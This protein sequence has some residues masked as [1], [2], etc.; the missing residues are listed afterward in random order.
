MAVSQL[1]PRI[2]EQSIFESFGC[3]LNGLDRLVKFT[4]VN[5]NISSLADPLSLSLSSITVQIISKGLVILTAASKQQLLSLLGVQSRRTVDRYMDHETPIKSPLLGPV[6]LLTKGNE[7]PLL[8]H[9][10]VHRVGR[11]LLLPD[12][13]IPGLESELELEEGP[14]YVY[15]KE[16]ELYAKFDSIAKAAIGLNPTQP[17]KRR[18]R[19]IKIGRLM[20]LEGLVNH[21]LGQFYFIENPNTN[22]FLLSQKGRY[23]CY[24]HDILNGTSL[25]F[26]GLKPVV[27]H[28]ENFRYENSKVT[29]ERLKTCYIN[30]STFTNARVLFNRFKIVPI[31]SS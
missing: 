10:I 26:D 11:D 29:Y 16:K 2:L 18:G 21:E 31:K 8:N 30:S 25:R 3:H 23:P 5:F 1:V 6:N 22:R 13:V 4:F 27:R 7:K 17:D 15:T 24:L 9:P 19:E 28:L 14:V 20:G 12:L